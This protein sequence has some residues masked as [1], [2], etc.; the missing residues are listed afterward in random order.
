MSSAPILSR[1][2]VSG[3][4]SCYMMPDE[5]PNGGAF[6]PTSPFASLSPNPG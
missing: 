2:I 4:G 1:Y 3:P 6:V 5:P